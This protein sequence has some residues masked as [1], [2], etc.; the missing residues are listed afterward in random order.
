MMAFDETLQSEEF[1]LSVGRE[2]LSAVAMIGRQ[3]PTNREFTLN[4]LPF[5]NSFARLPA[6]FFRPSRPQGLP[7]PYLVAVSAAAADLLHLDGKELGSPDFCDYFSGNT[8]L[9]GSEPLA[10]V[11]SGHQFGDWVGQLGDGRAQLLGELK[12]PGNTW[13]IQLKGAGPTP[14]CRGFDGRAVLRSSIREFL[15]SEAMAGLGVPTTRALCIVGSDL[16]IQRES[17]ETAAVVTRLAPSFVR[18]GS[19]QHW[20]GLDKDK[21]LKLLADYVIDRFMPHLRELAN[22]YQALLQDAA[23]LTGKMIAHWQAVGFMHGVMNTDN[24][25]ILGLTLDYGPFGFME[26][27]DAGHVCNHS[28]RFGRYAYRAQPRIAKWNLY[29]LGDALVTLIGHPDI[30]KAIVDEHYDLAYQSTFKSLMQAKLGLRVDQPSDDDFISQTFGLLQAH[31]PDY[32]LFFRHLS[33]LPGQYTADNE[34]NRT[35]APVRDL[36]LDREA[37]DVWLKLWRLRLSAEESDDH[38]RQAAMLAVNPKYILRNWVAEDAIRKAQAK[39]F[40]GVYEV[41][42]CLQRPFDEH[43][44]YERYAALPPDWANGLSVSC[45]S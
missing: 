12:T 18:F 43:P 42:H 28:D 14:Y 45:S 19:F 36:F 3:R 40:S 6:N 33:H 1:S 25:S 37:C 17:V 4:A 16:P 5:D 10:A 13:E 7:E 30:A 24:M 26:A 44:E 9:P 35:D 22:P 27:F 20:S 41:L 21:E 31:R 32:H 15:C 8:L 23:Q 39:D 29:A 38:K 2:N 11:Y 34:S